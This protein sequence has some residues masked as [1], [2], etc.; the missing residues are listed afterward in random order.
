MLIPPLTCTSFPHLIPTNTLHP[1]THRHPE[2]IGRTLTLA[3]P[4]A[5]TVQEVIA[6]CEK[7]A[8]ADAKVQ[9]VPVWLLKLT[10]NVLKSFQ[11][12][13]DASDR[14]VCGLLRGEGWVLGVMVMSIGGCVDKWSVVNN[15][16]MVCAVVHTNPTPQ[17]PNPPF[18]HLLMC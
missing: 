6:L 4:K 9:E 14:L 2:T 15:K 12:A 16:C 18:R 13:R 17:N 11:W 10:R 1:Q 3:G 7:Y 5:Y 8:D